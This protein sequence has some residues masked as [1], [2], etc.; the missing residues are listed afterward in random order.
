MGSL[1]LAEPGKVKRP[2][3]TVPAASKR[4]K[5]AAATSYVVPTKKSTG[6]R[7]V[8][9]REPFPGR[10]DARKGT[11]PARIAPCGA[12]AGV[13]NS[14][15]GWRP[16]SK[17]RPAVCRRFPGQ[18]AGN[19][20]GTTHHVPVNTPHPPP[21][22]AARGTKTHASKMMTVGLPGWTPATPKLSCQLNR[23]P[24]IQ[25]SFMMMRREVG[26]ANRRNYSALLLS[27]L[28]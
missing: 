4:R 12:A 28:D 14:P 27:N 5:L 17:V 21:A 24:L 1:E 23:T 3:P 25:S 2:R 16:S 10:L 26:I 13:E 7:R 8:M 18:R 22:E 19:R 11:T 15:G 6:C 9:F 20:S